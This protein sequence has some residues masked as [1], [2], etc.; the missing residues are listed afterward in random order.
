MDPM[1]RSPLLLAA[2][3]TLALAVAACGTKD[4][5][6][7]GF[8]AA[9]SATCRNANEQLDLIPSPGASPGANEDEALS[10]YLERAFEV[11]EQAADNI[12]ALPIPADLR[13]DRDALVDAMNEANEGLEEAA[14]AASTGDE[15]AIAAAVKKM[16]E[17][18][19]RF[20]RIA[21]R[22]G[23]DGCIDGGLRGSS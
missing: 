7:E 21:Q 23:I 8:V 15:D 14:A 17:G 19:E 20:R 4:L 10:A 9:A 13:A 6:P 22:L 11:N 3:V 16:T 2:V 12:L 1:S 18:Q 5:S